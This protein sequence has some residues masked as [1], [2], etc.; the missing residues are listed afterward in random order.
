MAKIPSARPPMPFG[1][2]QNPK[3]PRFGYMQ[4]SPYPIEIIREFRVMEEGYE[5]LKCESRHGDYTYVAKPL[6]LRTIEPID[7]VNQT[8]TINGIDYEFTA[9]NRRKVSD[10]DGVFFDEIQMITPDYHEGD[11]IFAMRTRSDG[12]SYGD[13]FEGLIRENEWVDM[14]LAGRQWAV[15]ILSVVVT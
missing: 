9:E 10:P 14:N 13:D 2:L 8:A 11:W 3:D 5:W 4:L 6:P 12:L 1:F 15:T 7:E